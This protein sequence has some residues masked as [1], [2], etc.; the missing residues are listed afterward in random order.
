LLALGALLFGAAA[1]T[2]IVFARE[3]YGFGGDT[4]RDL[5]REPQRRSRLPRAKGARTFGGGLTKAVRDFLPGAGRRLP[6]PG[7]AAGFAV[8]STQPIRHRRRNHRI[9][10]HDGDRRV[11]HGEVLRK[12]AASALREGDDAVG[13]PIE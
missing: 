8:P 11:G 6:I 1:G 7:L 4:D 3:A 13:A 10:V 12:I 5:E 2:G 9:G